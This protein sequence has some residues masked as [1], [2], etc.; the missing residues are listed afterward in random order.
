MQQGSATNPTIFAHPE[1]LSGITNIW[2]IWWI[3]GIT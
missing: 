1:V 3:L 2:W